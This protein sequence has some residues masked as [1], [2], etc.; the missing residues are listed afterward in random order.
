[1]PNLLENPLTRRK[2]DLWASLPFDLWPGPVI[3][4]IHIPNILGYTMIRS[5][6]IVFLV[7]VFICQSLIFA[8]ETR[9][10]QYYQQLEKASMSVVCIEGSKIGERNFSDTKEFGKAFTG[11]GTGIIIDSRGYIATNQHVVEGLQKIIVTTHDGEKYSATCLERDNDTDIALIKIDSSNPLQSISMGNSHKLRLGEH[12]NAI[13]NPFGYNFSL[14]EGI[15]S[16]LDCEVPASE[17]L[18][19]KNMIQTSAQINPGNSGGP[20]LNS[21][22]EVVAMNVAIHSG[23]QGIAFAMP[24][25]AVMDISARLVSKQTSRF[26]YH[27]M[28]V[29]ESDEGDLIVVDVDSGSPA[30]SI[31]MSPGD[32]VSKVDDCDILN[33]IDFQRAFLGKQANDSVNLE[34][35][36]SDENL[37][38][39]LK[40]GNPGTK[41]QIASRSTSR[42]QRG[43]NQSANRATNNQD[44]QSSKDK[45]KD[46]VWEVFG[47]KVRPVTPTLLKN[48]SPEIYNDY[49]DGAVQIITVRTNGI[50]SKS[51]LKQGDLLTGIIAGNKDGQSWTV[52][53]EGNLNWIAERWNSQLLETD[54]AEFHVIRDRKPYYPMVPIEPSTIASPE[55]TRTGVR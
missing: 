34:I 3:L 33:T 37:N 7:Q 29:E 17:K 20:L 27:G 22:G 41:T 18:I 47:V 10:E 11:M 31:N 28:T 32:I 26:C 51:G 21:Q 43:S 36:R 1:M 16:R 13:G 49:P 44:E 2:E 46:L 9:D 24:I 25:E 48:Y 52:T 4:F 8:S 45:D 54:A 6:I 53:S 42:S 15:V 30:D 14:T 40:L 39:A 12:V 38:V 55:R 19:Y 5:S 35:K 23:A 50:L